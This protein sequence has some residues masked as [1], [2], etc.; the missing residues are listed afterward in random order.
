MTWY[1]I[2]LDDHA[3]VP[4]AVG[5]VDSTTHIN[6][7]TGE[8]E[9]TGY[10]VGILDKNFTKEHTYQDPETGVTR[11]SEEARTQ[12]FP[13]LPRVARNSP[14]LANVEAM[15]RM[16]DDEMK[17]I[18]MDTLQEYL[19]E[20]FL[21][22][23]KPA[24]MEQINSVMDCL[25]S[26][27]YDQL[28]L[29]HVRNVLLRS[30]KVLLVT[31]TN[32]LGLTLRS[33]EKSTGRSTAKKESS[34]MTGSSSS[35]RTPTT[36]NATRRSGNRARSTSIGQTE[37]KEYPVADNARLEPCQATKTQ[38]LAKSVY[39]K[40]IPQYGI[41]PAP[42]RPSTRQGAT[43]QLPH[44]N[45][46]TWSTASTQGSAMKDPRAQKVMTPKMTGQQAELI[47]REF[48]KSAL[49]KDQ[50]EE[51]ASGK[52]HARGYPTSSSPSLK[53]EEEDQ[54]NRCVNMIKDLMHD[55]KIN[56]V[57]AETILMDKIAVM[58]QETQNATGSNDTKILHAAVQRL[59]EAGVE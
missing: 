55:Q 19:L 57:K 40:Q 30:D 1:Q 46:D 18:V 36:T 26:R 7:T 15:N 27:L 4:S 37:V 58:D 6:P 14:S 5:T 42:S 10:V 29:P 9:Y 2:A 17:K 51:M 41:I 32:R 21:T 31:L 35:A 13:F 22:K 44:G 24:P 54:I 59:Q 43:E 12:Y 38:L 11:W 16:S 23:P 50:T 28:D 8:K 3:G 47:E 48:V 20:S 49:T 45:E 34:S 25:E 56:M 39:E 52:K 33:I 53:K